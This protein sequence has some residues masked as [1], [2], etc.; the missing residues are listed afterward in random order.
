MQDASMIIAEQITDLDSQKNL[1]PNV[2]Q[3]NA[4]KPFQKNNNF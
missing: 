1:M 3:K 4:L 2:E